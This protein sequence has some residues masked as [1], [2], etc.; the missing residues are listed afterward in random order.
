M[1]YIIYDDFQPI[2]FHIF[3]KFSFH[4][5]GRI[6]FNDKKL[7]LRGKV[8]NESFAASSVSQKIRIKKNLDRILNVLI[9]IFAYFLMPFPCNWEPNQEKDANFFN[10]F[11][12]DYFEVI[13]F[14]LFFTKKRKGRIWGF[15]E[16]ACVCI[17]LS[18]LFAN[19]KRRRYSPFCPWH[20]SGDIHKGY[21][22]RFHTNRKTM[23]LVSSNTNPTTNFI[24]Q[25]TIF[26]KGGVGWVGGCL[27]FFFF[28]FFGLCVVLMFVGWKEKIPVKLLTLVCIHTRVIVGLVANH[29]DQS[30]MFGQ[31]K[32]REQQSYHIYLHTFSTVQIM[33]TQNHFPEPNQL[34][35]AS[36]F[37][38]F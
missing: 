14:I 27:E 23:D 38:E 26:S 6:I 5:I 16:C 10:L 18:C 25:E 35:L 20:V 33:L 30:F 19:R 15:G 21:C 13:N 29:L 7:D 2:N 17:F 32:N 4:S 36:L 1:I 37:N 22:A 3:H 12:L 9:I 11:I 34:V 31:S 28:F 8:I 24:W